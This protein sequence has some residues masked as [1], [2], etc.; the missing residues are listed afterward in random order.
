[1][2]IN[3]PYLETSSKELPLEESDLHTIDSILVYIAQNSTL[4]AAQIETDQ[5]DDTNSSTYPESNK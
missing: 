3:Q 2:N 5:A 1:M 4:E